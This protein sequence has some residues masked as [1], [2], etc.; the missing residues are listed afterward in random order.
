MDLLWWV[1]SEVREPI[2]FI[3]SPRGV[4][5]PVLGI[6]T[7]F[8]LTWVG[9]YKAAA[10]DC[11][12]L[13]G[14]RFTH[15]CRSEMASGHTVPAA[16]AFPGRLAED[17][18]VCNFSGICGVGGEFALMR[19]LAQWVVL[20]HASHGLSEDHRQ[21][22]TTCSPGSCNPLFHFLDWLCGGFPGGASGKRTCLSMQET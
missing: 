5:S 3:S 13:E 21:S 22:D 1:G 14:V 2:F 11:F 12:D 20:R 18:H 19:S 16:V 9:Q 6:I 4:L 7:V 17:R 8:F 10:S 15:V